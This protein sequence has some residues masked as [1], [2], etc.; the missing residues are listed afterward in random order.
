MLCSSQVLHRHII[1]QY[2]IW[3]AI[4]LGC[5]ILFPLA[6]SAQT[7]VYATFSASNFNAPNVKWQ[8][9][10]TLGIYD[11]FVSVPFAGIGLDARATLLG[12]GDTSLITGLIGPRIQFRPHIIPLMPYFEGLVGGGR[13]K[14]G[15]GVAAQDKTVAAYEGV[16][17]IDW[18]ILPRIDWRVVDFSFGGVSNVGDVTPRTLSTGLV[19]RL[20]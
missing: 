19:V 10:S 3:A 7:G 11:D 12:H 14:I 18:T 2:L 1:R 15:Q 5:C 17:G 9:G 6:A 13:V 16:A 20:P 4:L 8:Y